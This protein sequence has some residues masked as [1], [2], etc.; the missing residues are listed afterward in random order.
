MQRQAYD[1][2]AGDG[3]VNVRITELAYVAPLSVGC[4]YRSKEITCETIQASS[5]WKIRSKKIHFYLGDVIAEMTTES[6]IVILDEPV[7]G[8]FYVNY[9]HLEI[10]LFI[11]CLL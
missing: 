5:L 11:V 1:D 8:C 3:Q 4:I 7:L 10:F 2:P 9:T 6:L